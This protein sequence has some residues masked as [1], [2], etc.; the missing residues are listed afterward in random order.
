M[1]FC[2]DNF[3][4]KE[5]DILW[6]MKEFRVDRKEVLRQFDILRDHEFRRS[7]SDW[8]RVFRNWMR[9]CEEIESFR[10]ERKVVQDVYTEEQRQVDAKKAE[11]NL[12]KLMRIVK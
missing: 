11:E 7:Y 6:A 4:P 5:K 2:P 1:R 10:R 8:N 12:A 9:K 3:K